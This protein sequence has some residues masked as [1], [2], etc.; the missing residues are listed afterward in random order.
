MEVQA[1][2]VHACLR[3]GIPCL[4][5]PI[6]GDQFSFAALV[7]AKGLGVQ[8]DTK[9]SQLSLGEI[10][11]AVRQASACME[12]CRILGAQIQSDSCK[13]GGVQRLANLLENSI[14]KWDQP[15]AITSIITWNAE[16]NR[17]CKVYI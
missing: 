13:S 1:G 7:Q 2:A 6:M 4:I 12:N 11:Q 9:W 14:C 17:I 15:F 16:E 8:C 5:S 3:A 10:V